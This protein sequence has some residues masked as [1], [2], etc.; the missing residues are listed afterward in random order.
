MWR[1]FEKLKPNA[2]AEGKPNS[3]APMDQESSTFDEAVLSQMA[4]P[5]N[6]PS[7][8]NDAAEDSSSIRA[9]QALLILG[10]IAAMIRRIVILLAQPILSASELDAL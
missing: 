8:T 2:P 3:Q 6:I 4:E 10:M 7:K 1:F 9:K 5:S